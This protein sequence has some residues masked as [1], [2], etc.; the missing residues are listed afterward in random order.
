MERIYFRTGCILLDKVL[1]GAKNILGVPAGKF[2]NIVG[3]KS[4]GKNI[5]FK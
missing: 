3:D 5:S 1:G 4:A 2:I